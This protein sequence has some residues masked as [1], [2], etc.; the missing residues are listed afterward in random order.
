MANDIPNNTGRNGGMTNSQGTSKPQR[1]ASARS[2]AFKPTCVVGA[3]QTSCQSST[4]SG[5]DWRF[6]YVELGFTL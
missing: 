1:R 4:W 5:N 6:R 2:Q 3:S